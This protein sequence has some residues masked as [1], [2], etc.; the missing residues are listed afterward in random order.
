MSWEN[1]VKELRNVRAGDLIPDKRNWRVHPTGQRK[2]LEEVLST[3]GFAAA[4]IA[5]ETDQGLVLVDGHLRADLDEDQVIPVLIVD[6]DEEEAATVMATMDPLSQMAEIDTDALQALV[7]N[8][9]D[10]GSLMTGHLNDIL[11]APPWTPEGDRAYVEAAPS[12]RD[13]A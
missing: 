6:L 3:V 4:A 8:M 11:G 1:R 9:L 7:G 5:R 13:R 12:G 10:V 2:A